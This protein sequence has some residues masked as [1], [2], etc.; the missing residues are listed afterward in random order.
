M[1][2][3]S[4]GGE[5][6]GGTALLIVEGSRIPFGQADVELYQ[7]ARLPADNRPDPEIREIG[8]AHV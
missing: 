1:S 6:D 8:R 3:D 7:A 5:K 2:G 4:G